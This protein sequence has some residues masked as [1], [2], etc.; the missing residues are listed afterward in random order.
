MYPILDLTHHTQDLHWYLRSLEEVIIRALANTSGLHGK[1]IDGLTGVWV[2][3]HK[4]AAIGVRARKWVTY[5][6][7]A[8]NVSTVLQP[9][10]LIIPCGIAGRPVGSV[11]TALSGCITAGAQVAT[12]AAASAALTA[13]S[14]CSEQLN[15]VGNVGNNRSSSNNTGGCQH[16][17]SGDDMP[18]QPSSSSQTGDKWQQQLYSVRN[19]T[20]IVEYRC[21]LLEAFEDVFGLHLQPASQQQKEQLLQS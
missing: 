8:L 9:F 5:H 7:L 6:G 20:L 13:S 11:R 18:M 15:V 17:S 21:A 2:Q 1:R 19:D 14:A 12:A 10:K 4:L 16:S 3:G